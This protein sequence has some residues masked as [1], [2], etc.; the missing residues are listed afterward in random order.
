MESASGQ[1]E[2]ERPRPPPFARAASRSSTSSTKTRSTHISSQ[3]SFTRL[4]PS[5]QH[6]ATHPT[7]RFHHSACGRD[8]SER[9]RSQLSREASEDS[10]QSTPPVSSFLQ[11][12]LQKERK[13]S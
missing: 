2:G 4:P 7:H 10:R 9:P 13:E 6:S 5:P 11:E 1:Q 3:T 12:R 8:S